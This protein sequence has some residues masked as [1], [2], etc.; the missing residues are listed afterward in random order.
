MQCMKTLL[1]IAHCMGD[2]LNESWE[3]VLETFQHLDKFWYTTP[4]RP[5][6]VT[7]FF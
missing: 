5:I 3:I 7:I 6:Q 1:N 4:Y 2:I